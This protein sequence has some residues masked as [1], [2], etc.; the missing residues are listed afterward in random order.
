MM[1]QDKVSG[2]MVH[3][4]GTMNDCSEIQGFQPEPQFWTVPLTDCHSQNKYG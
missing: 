4:E 1:A 2:L 3:P